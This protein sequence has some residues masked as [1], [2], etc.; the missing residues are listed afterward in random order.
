MVVAPEP[1]LVP[2]LTEVSATQELEGGRVEATWRKHATE[3]GRWELEVATPPSH[4]VTV[5]LPLSRSH[6]SISEGGRL[7]WQAA[8][9]GTSTRAQDNFFADTVQAVVMSGDDR[10]AVEVAQG[11]GRAVYTVRVY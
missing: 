5:R 2:Q 11:P 8:A 10:W 7:L 9:A 6:G 1:L 4:I 3:E